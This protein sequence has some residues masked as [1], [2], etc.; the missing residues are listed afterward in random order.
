MTNAPANITFQEHTELIS[1]L[2][3]LQ[4]FY[5]WIFLKDNP[6]KEFKNA[7]YQT[8][9]LGRKL[10]SEPTGKDSAQA[11]FKSEKWLQI[12]SEMEKIY[13]D[14]KSAITPTP[15]ENSAMQ[16]LSAII[17]QFAEKTFF[18]DKK[19]DAY[20]CGCI[21]YDP[22]S[23]SNPDTCFFHIGNPIAPKSIFDDPQYLK[24]S[25]LEM[26]RQVKEKYN[27]NSV[28]TSTWLNS[29]D[30]WLTY[31]P[32]SWRKNLST[33]NTNIK[34][35]YGFWGQFIS[36]KGTFNHKYADILRTTKKFPFYPKSSK[37][38]VEELHKHLKKI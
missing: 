20:Q 31:F 33:A 14:T 17:A 35:H 29:M 26:T 13:R 9:D 23:K 5:L 7:L 22:P 12:E 6:E 16:S 24:N 4:F 28:A 36:A 34:W 15:F 21:K 38:S 11:N 19:Y 30:Q 25:L 2:L 1:E 27:A 37:C 10:D 32:E 18:K 3:K 8:V